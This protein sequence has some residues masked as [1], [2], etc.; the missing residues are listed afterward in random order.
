M[1]H[2]SNKHERKRQRLSRADPTTVLLD[3][4]SMVHDSNER[5][6]KRSDRGLENY[7]MASWIKPNSNAAKGH[8]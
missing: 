8:D 3:N 4:G 5:G 2:K 1:V 7:F 6:Q